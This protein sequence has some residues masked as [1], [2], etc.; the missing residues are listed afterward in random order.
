MGHGGRL[1]DTYLDQG[2]LAYDTVQADLNVTYLAY[3]I[4]FCR[5]GTR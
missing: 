5:F 2:F 1:S 3:R 4:R